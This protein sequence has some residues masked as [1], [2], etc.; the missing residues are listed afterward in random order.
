ME[1]LCKQ[2]TCIRTV[3]TSYLS[4]KKKKKK[5]KELYQQA[6]KTRALL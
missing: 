4:K 5:K 2:T 3:P 6:D 1:M